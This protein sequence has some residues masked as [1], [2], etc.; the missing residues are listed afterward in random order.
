MGDLK[1]HIVG[2]KLTEARRVAQE[3]GFTLR[4]KERDGKSL[5]G[6]CDRRNNRINVAV[7]QDE[8]VK[9]LGVG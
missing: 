4:V 7:H 5:F 6:T 3:A 9:T 1:N 2:M 8:V